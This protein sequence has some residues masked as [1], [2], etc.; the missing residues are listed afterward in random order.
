MKMFFVVVPTLLLG[1]GGCRPSATSP[2]ASGITRTYAKS[3]PAAPSA[4]QVRIVPQRIQEDEKLVHWRWTIVGDRNWTLM[5]QENT[6]IS[7]GGSYPLDAT[8][9]SGGTNAYEVD[10]KITAEESPDGRTTLNYSQSISSIGVKLSGTIHGTVDSGG[11][12]SG[13]GTLHQELRK[14]GAN[15]AARS[16]L[17]DDQ[18]VPL[19]VDQALIQIEAETT[20]GQPFQK[21]FHLKISP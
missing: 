10:L 13:A 18:T 2:T 5:Q 4:G 6:D 12:T 20:E 15:S 14:I 3:V 8:D 16:L 17:S 7:L 19:P 9:R 11:G 21:V 1:L